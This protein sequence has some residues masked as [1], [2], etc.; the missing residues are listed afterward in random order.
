MESRYNAMQNTSIV[1]ND[2][3]RSSP[4]IT[5]PPTIPDTDASLINSTDAPMNAYG[6]KSLSC[7]SRMMRYITLVEIRLWPATNAAPT[8]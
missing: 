2:G 6:F 3:L 7:A 1:L 4:A 5:V 8:K